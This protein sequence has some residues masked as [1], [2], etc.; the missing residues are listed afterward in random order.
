MTSLLSL[1]AAF[2]LSA[3][4]VRSPGA[5]ETFLLATTEQAP[6]IYYYAWDA[7][8]TEEKKKT[9][10]AFDLRLFR[11]A[12]VSAAA[13]QL[14]D[15]LEKM[16]GRRPVLTPVEDANE[17]SRT[18]LGLVLGALARDLGVRMEARSPSRDG[19]RYQAIPPLV[20]IVGESDRGVFYGVCAF[21]ESLG[22]GW[23]TP[24]E[25]GEVIP[26]L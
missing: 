2:L 23:Y 12:S 25:V 24:G 18:A 13:E 4:S 3:A 19:F 11:Y 14:A 10:N 22:C 17:V 1:S 6:A 26:R 9:M 8:L 20:L 21:L 7:G 15:A 16:T 5:A